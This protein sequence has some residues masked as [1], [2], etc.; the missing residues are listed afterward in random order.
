MALAL[1]YRY[2]PAQVCGWMRER[3]EGAAPWG[4]VARSGRDRV[5]GMVRRSVHGR[6][7]SAERLL[8]VDR[9]A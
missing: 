2:L 7:L 9:P 4:A 3:Y 5:E 6:C 1:R 8:E